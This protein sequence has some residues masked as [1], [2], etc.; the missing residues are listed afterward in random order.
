MRPAC[1]AEQIYEMDALAV[2]GFN[3]AGL[4]FAVLYKLPNESHVQYRPMSKWQDIPLI[5][6]GAIRLVANGMATFNF[7]PLSARK[8]R[9]AFNNPPSSFQ[10]R[11]SE[12][13][14]FAPEA[15]LC[16]EAKERII[17]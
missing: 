17:E 1:A 10:V 12:L 13:K 5:S 6:L 14:D 9:I 15:L 11:L 16:Y 4:I 8:L 7:P 2:T 3:L